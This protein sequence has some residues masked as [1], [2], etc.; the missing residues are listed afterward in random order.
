M[1]GTFHGVFLMLLGIEF[2]LNIDE[3]Y[4]SAYQAV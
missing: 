4:L 1:K 3:S 2:I